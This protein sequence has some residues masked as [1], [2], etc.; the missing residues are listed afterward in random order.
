MPGGGGFIRA[1]G[2]TPITTFNSSSSIATTGTL[3]TPSAGVRIVHLKGQFTITGAGNQPHVV[4]NIGSNTI[5]PNI[6][7]T[8][9]N[10]IYLDALIIFNAALTSYDFVDLQVCNPTGGGAVAGPSGSDAG[11]GIAVAGGL[12]ISITFPAANSVSTTVEGYTM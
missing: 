12:A 10:F 6:N 9:A 1:A 2:A 8:G 11:S 7:P 5:A 3:V 4:V